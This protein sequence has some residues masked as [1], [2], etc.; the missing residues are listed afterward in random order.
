MR[1]SP[2]KTNFPWLA[3]FISSQGGWSKTQFN[4]AVRRFIRESQQDDAELKR[5]PRYRSKKRNNRR[6]MKLWKKE[7]RQTTAMSYYLKLSNMELTYER[8][9]T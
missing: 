7:V 2:L 8:T 3:M 6:L 5:H 1:K 4:R 9:T